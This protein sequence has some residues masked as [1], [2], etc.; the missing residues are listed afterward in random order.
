M[1]SI[2]QERRLHKIYLLRDPWDGRVRYVGV[3]VSEL[4]VRLNGHICDARNRPKHRRDYW[5]RQVLDSGLYPIIEL[6]EETEDRD[7]EC[8]WIAKYQ[9]ETELTNVTPGGGGVPGHKWTEEFRQHMK[10]VLSGRYRTWEHIENQREV[11]RSRKRR[12]GYKGVYLDKRSGNY[13][14]Q[15]RIDNA[16]CSFGCFV[17]EEDAARR[18]DEIVLEFYGEGCYLNFPERG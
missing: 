15:L 8:F 2:A 18:Y 4:S 16:T 9:F 12:N 5:I 17:S 11:R 14:V 3:T 10:K 1:K 7:R 6:I 13:R